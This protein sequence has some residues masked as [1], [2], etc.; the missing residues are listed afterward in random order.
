M[1]SWMAFGLLA[2]LGLTIGYVWPQLD[3]VVSRWFYE[4]DIGFAAANQPLFKILHIMAT[5]GAWIFGLLLL[6][7][8]IFTA[9]SRRAFGGMGAKEWLFVTLALLIG[10]VLIANV[11]FKDH[12]GRARPHQ[13]VEFG[14]QEAFSPA[15]IPQPVKFTNGSFVAGDP[16]FGFY[17]ASFA[18]VAPPRRRRLMNVAG[19]L[20]GGLFGFARIAMGAH[21]LSDVLFSAI[22]MLAAPA[23][24]HVVMYRLRKA[25]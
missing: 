12:W 25:D 22:F 23:L 4:P 10:P 3:L 2:G 14:G 21:F 18:Y 8:T 11:G 7:L 20:I 9:L 1:K 6:G 16:S 13:I 24:L 19:V 15:L 5:K 17:L